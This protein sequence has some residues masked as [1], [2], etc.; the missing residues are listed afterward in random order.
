MQTAEP[1]DEL[2]SGGQEQVE[3]VAQD[4]LVAE[5]GYVA[6]LQGLHRPPGGQGHEHRGGHLAVG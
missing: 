3:G 5:P 2:R 1:M 6:W 4:Q